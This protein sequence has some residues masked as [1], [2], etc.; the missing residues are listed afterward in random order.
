MKPHALVTFLL[1]RKWIF[2]VDNRAGQE[3][4]YLFEPIIAHSI[5]GVPFSSRKSPIRRRD[6]GRKGRQVDCVRDNHAYE[7]KIRVT[8][9]ASG[10][11]RWREELDFPVDCRVSGYT[12]V[13]VVLDP[14]DNPKLQDLIRA[15]E[16]ENGEVYVGDG[17]WAHLESVAGKTMAL[18][19]ERY[20]RAPI[21]W[22]LKD[23]PKQL[24]DLMLAMRE[25]TVTVSVGGE[26]YSFPRAAVPASEESEVL[27]PEDIEEES[28]GI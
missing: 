1:W 26:T 12:P 11:G 2:D 23:C 17:A 24:S 21:D 22:V 19:L 27:M 6:D 4:G 18:F 16:R 9:A 7:I 5:G 14:A 3:T 10:Q 25:D 13:L 28:P 8:I 20:V 15:F